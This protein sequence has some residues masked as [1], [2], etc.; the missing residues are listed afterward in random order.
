MK[1]KWDQETVTRF[2][3]STTV[4]VIGVL[5]FF[6]LQ[7]FTE[8][9]LSIKQF[10][11]VFAPFLVGIIIAYLLA[12][13]LTQIEKFLNLFL[14]RVSQFKFIPLLLKSFYLSC[15]NLTI[16][17]YFLYRNRKHVKSVLF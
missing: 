17:V 5:L 4:V 1:I 11:G 6:F 13:L 16:F 8:V 3:V 7:N 14:V 10:L 9:L 15:R 2:W 12:P